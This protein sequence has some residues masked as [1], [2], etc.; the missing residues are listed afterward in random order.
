MPIRAGSPGLIYAWLMPPP[1]PDGSPLTAVLGPTNTGKT[2][3]A[4]ERMLGHDSG[5]IGLPLRL[6]AREIY[7]RVTRQLGEAEVALVTGEERRVPARPRYWVCTVEAMPVEREVDFLA[8]DEIQLATHAERGHVFTDRLLHAR[9]RLETWFMGADTMRPVLQQLLPT[10]RIA[11][12]PRLSKLACRGV[13]SLAALK[14][15]SAVVAFSAPRVYEL[16]E[17]LRARRGGAA[18]V[19]GALSPR[20]RNQ[21]VALYESGEVDYM[22]A[23]DAIGMGLNMDV[24]HVAFADLAKFDGRETR[25][26]EAAEL[27][28][29]AGRAGRY[30]DD[31]SFGTLSPLPALDERLARSIEMHHFPVVRRLIWRNSDLDLSSI[32]ALVASLSERPRSGLLRLVE[33]TEDHSALVALASR[34]DIRSRARGEEA[35]SLLWDVC[36]IPDFRQLLFDHHVE[37]LGELFQQLSG[38]RRRLD[39]DFVAERVGRID[40]TEGDIETLMMRMAFVRTWTYVSHRESWLGDAHHW[41]ERTRA[42]EDRLSDALHRRLVARFVDEGQKTSAPRARPRPR[43][44]PQSRTEDERR[45]DGPFAQLFELRQR[46][47]DPLPPAPDADEW[48]EALVEAPHERFTLDPE[49]RI[50]DGDLVLGRMIRGAD[51]LRP[52]VTLVLDDSIGSG[53][54]SRIQRRLVAWTR[55]LVSSTLAPLRS[56]EARN[57]SA[58]GRGLVYQLEQNLGTVET[59]Q[60]RAQ[61]AALSPDDRRLLARLGVR[62]GKRLVYV[63]SLLEPA[64]VHSRVALCSAWLGHR[65]RIELPR[66]GVESL[67]AQRDLDAASHLAIGYPR[68][69]PRAI[70]ADTAERVARQLHHAARRGTF[71]APEGLSAR[72]ECSDDELGAVIEAFGY[73]RVKG[74]QF[75]ARGRGRPRRRGRRRR[76]DRAAPPDG[77]R[78]D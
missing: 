74:G 34:P 48:L 8:V 11:G 46:M 21:Q 1:A 54:R 6:L 43:R 2:H 47:R 53:S 38:P 33:R 70:R 59:T 60:A 28:Q 61:L 41:Q 31:G 18:V 72:F 12:H 78:T 23:T 57:L 50:L 4:V 22:V 58:S 36:R 64:A 15:R 25:P 51:L 71:R 19:L 7:D 42:I 44:L 5:M 9:G 35:V 75:A 20:A 27:A 37:L 73:R 30:L 63:R 40:D 68:F 76:P 65:T 14:P 69:G 16:A 13:S 32:D 26:L 62:L 10:I 45:P 24:R 67:P 49:G 17:R 3:R 66:P 55:D 52:E 39:P 77:A 29:I 56:D